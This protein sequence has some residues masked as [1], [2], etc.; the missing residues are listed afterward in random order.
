MTASRAVIFVELMSAKGHV[1]LN[2]FIISALGGRV[3]SFLVGKQVAALY[4]DVDHETFNDWYLGSYRFVSALGTFFQGMRALCVA[5]RRGVSTICFLSY[6]ASVLL[7]LSPLAS[8]LGLHLFVF[9]HNTVPPRRN[10][11]L[12]LQRL[13]SGRVIRLC[14]TPHIRD[15]YRKLGQRALYVPHPLLAQRRERLLED[16]DR[17]NKEFVVSRAREFRLRVFCPSSSMNAN[18]LRLAIEDRPD[19]FFIVKG[20][21]DLVRHNVFSA[22]RFR[23]LSE[24]FAIVDFT[25]LPVSF[26]HRVSGFLFESLAMNVPVILPKG[27]LYE[28]AFRHFSAHIVLDEGRWHWGDRARVGLDMRKHNRQVCRRLRR[29]L[30]GSIC[31][32]EH[33]AAGTTQ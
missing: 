30:S 5:Y 12:L 13:V 23:S 8:R 3:A 29:L 9:E 6:D 31:A 24:W 20:H 16:Q 22:P 18:E 11:K 15:F 2:S 33:V 1:T 19:V 4:D 10:M 25:Y 26:S 14:F 32:S 28:Y 7:L 21:A 17:N 27:E